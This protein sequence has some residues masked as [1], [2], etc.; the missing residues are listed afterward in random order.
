M[1]SISAKVERN[2]SMRLL[3]IEKYDSDK[4]SHYCSLARSKD[5]GV[6]Y[7]WA[8]LFEI[9]ETRKLDEFFKMINTFEP[10]GFFGLFYIFTIDSNVYIGCSKDGLG[11]EDRPLFKD[12]QNYYPF[13]TTKQAFCDLTC[14]WLE[15]YKK[16][17]PGIAIE[18]VAQD[19]WQVNALT[20]E[21]VNRY[22]KINRYR[23]GAII[24]DDWKSKIKY[25][26]RLV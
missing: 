9:I 14:R 2:S 18:E 7:L 26:G 6:G 3:C 4:I 22:Q 20:E 12:D 11:V 25:D 21:A 8:F 1:I 15:L 19:V 24:A 23:N 16:A 5:R 10:E 13:R 17:S